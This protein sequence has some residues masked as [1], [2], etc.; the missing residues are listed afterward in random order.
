VGQKVKY[1]IED[2]QAFIEQRT[3]ATVEV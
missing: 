3:R 1:K 2:L